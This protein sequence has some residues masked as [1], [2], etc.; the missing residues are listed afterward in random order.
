MILYRP[1]NS[2]GGADHGWLNTK[3]T[4]SFADYHDENWMNFRSLRVLNEDWIGCGEG[5]PMHPHRDMEIITH[6]L[7]GKI[8]HRDSMGFESTLQAGDFQR[9]SAGTGVRHSEFNPDPKAATHIVQ[10]WLKP[11]RTGHKPRYDELHPAKDSD[12]ILACSPDGREGSLAI[13]Q[14]VTLRKLRISKGSIKSVSI[15]PQRHAWIQVLSGEGKI[16]DQ[17]IVA[18]DGA[19]IS[20]V[21]NFRLSTQSAL[22][23]LLFDLA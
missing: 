10:I 16:D 20:Q 6:V 18:G 15:S 11:D 14:D 17:A 23:V 13:H 5:F 1:S 7:S 22:E 12:D 8:G 9:M 2:R 19:G 21:A 3:H 4:F